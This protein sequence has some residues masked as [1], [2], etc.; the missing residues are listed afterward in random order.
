MGRAGPSTG[1]VTTFVPVRRDGL[2][3]G[4]P[5][6]RTT[7]QASQTS[8]SSPTHLLHHHDH[9]QVY[10]V[11]ARGVEGFLQRLERSSTMEAPEEFFHSANKR[12]RRSED[13]TFAHD[14]DH[15]TGWEEARKKNLRR[16]QEEAVRNFGD[17]CVESPGILKDRTTSI[18]CWLRGQ[19]VGD[20]EWAASDMHLKMDQS[21][22]QVAFRNTRPVSAAAEAV[23]LA[24]MSV[25]SWK[26][27]FREA[28]TGSRFLLRTN[29]QLAAVRELWHGTTVSAGLAI[30]RD[31]IKAK[32]GGDPRGVY[33]SR[34]LEDAALS[35]YNNG[36]VVQLNKRAMHAA[37]AT[38]RS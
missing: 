5:R 33:G 34:S 14:Q 35:G 26:C 32:R 9:Y 38:R 10:K 15:P 12:C 13:C 17:Q 2:S 4:G 25:S 16:P 6:F 30:L 23:C 20:A 24:L 3:T 1:G 7:T 19:D 28:T 11:W 8:Q 36:C 29:L 22:V 31:G 37:W 21:R 27:W 18:R